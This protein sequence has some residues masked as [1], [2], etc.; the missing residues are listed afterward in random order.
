MFKARIR[1]E[2]SLVLGHDVEAEPLVD[3]VGDAL[4]ARLDLERLVGE[5]L[6]RRLVV[7]HHAKEARAPL[8]V[9]VVLVPRRPQRLLLHEK[10]V[11]RPSVQLVQRARIDGFLQGRTRLVI[12][13]A[14]TLVSLMFLSKM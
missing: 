7:G 2:S 13:S 14:G 12:N 11:P 3:G 8:V 6:G 1:E 4:D 9:A 5:H 10:E